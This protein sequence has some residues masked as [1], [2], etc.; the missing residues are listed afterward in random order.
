MNWLKKLFTRERK[1]EPYVFDQRIILDD[2]FSR[3]L[4]DTKEFYMEAIKHVHPKAVIAVIED[5][6]RAINKLYQSYK[7]EQGEKLWHF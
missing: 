1:P 2:Q 7:I 4:D 6:K 3:E 5:R